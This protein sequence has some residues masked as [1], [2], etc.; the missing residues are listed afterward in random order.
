[1]SEPSSGPRQPRVA[2]VIPC[3]NDGRFVTD[4]VHS[5]R[6]Q[7]EPCEIVV[8]DDGSSDPETLRILDQLERESV[9]VVHQ[10]NAGLSAARMAGVAAC[11]APYVQPLDADDRLAPGVLGP[12]ADTL[13]AN[14]GA[15]AAWGFTEAFGADESQNLHSDGFDPWRLTFLN[16]VPTTILARREALL[17][18][19]GWELADAGYE[20][21]DLNLKAAEAGWL[22]IRIDHAHTQYRQ[23]EESRM[24]DE[25]IRNHERLYQLLRQRHHPLFSHRREHRRHS[26][27]RATVKAAWTAI[28]LL[29][30]VSSYRKMRWC[31]LARDLLEPEMRS[32]GTPGLGE[33]IRRKLGR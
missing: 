15:T 9:H 25:A 12:L 29:P 33:R 26:R 5:S 7:E 30:S 27:T 22:G 20:D 10:A 2:V 28:D 17:E 16:E 3:F 4:A 11:R 13:D 1:V 19:G 24:L 18:V 21:W 23:H 8:V 14:P 6:E 31:F 32:P